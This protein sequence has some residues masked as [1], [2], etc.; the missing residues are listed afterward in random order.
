MIPPSYTRAIVIPAVSDNSVVDSNR[1]D[2]EPEPD[3]DV[4][5][6]SRIDEESDDDFPVVYEQVDFRKIS[7]NN[8]LGMTRQQM[9]LALLSKDRTGKQ[10]FDDIDNVLSSDDKCDDLHTAK[11]VI[12]DFIKFQSDSIRAVVFE[13]RAR[14]FD[15]SGLDLSGMNFE[16]LNFREANFSNSNLSGANFSGATLTF[17]KFND[18]KLN[19]AKFKKADLVWGE[20]ERADLTGAD[21]SGADLCQANMSGANLNFAN[22]NAESVLWTKFCRVNFKNVN[23]EGL[24]FQGAIFDGANMENA[25]FKGT[26]LEQASFVGTNLKR[27]N[28][29][30][31]DLSRIRMSKAILIGA[32]FVG[33]N[34]EYADLS[35]ADLRNVDFRGHE[36]YGARFMGANLDHANF[37]GMNLSQV[38]FNE[39]DLS[40]ADLSGANLAS[41]VF[42]KANFSRANLRLANLRGT[43]F[44]GAILFGADLRGAWCLWA[45]FSIRCGV[46]P[47]L[48]VLADRENYSFR[49]KSLRETSVQAG[50]H[51]GLKDFVDPFLSGRPALKPAIRASAI[52]SR[53]IRP[54]VVLQAA[55]VQKAVV[56]DVTKKPYSVMAVTSQSLPVTPRSF[57]GWISSVTVTLGQ[58]FRAVHRRLWGLS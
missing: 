23:F 44:I 9:E 24:N 40:D 25:S 5:G 33:A 28:F 43:N 31:I 49:V 41:T 2:F 8:I 1:D 12:V 13:Y 37:R 53:P 57:W 15:L 38:N 48:F 35:G 52:Q 30:G 26:N 34:F 22:L 56:V 55:A 16:G 50:D 32:I 46:D 7:L 6:L 17:A 27:A 20:F 45:K 47:N 42:G 21:F 36:L 58:F 3:C 29:S 39:A 18:S 10:F 54:I 19:N 14:R 11:Q 4:A 51:E